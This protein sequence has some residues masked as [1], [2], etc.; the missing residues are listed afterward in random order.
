MNRSMSVVVFGFAIAIV[1]GIARADVH[2]EA[3]TSTLP[4]YTPTAATETPTVAFTH[5]GFGVSS[6]TMGGAG[7]GEGAG[8]SRAHELCP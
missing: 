5:S 7:Y 6:G 3:P 1:P 2:D 8:G 4:Q